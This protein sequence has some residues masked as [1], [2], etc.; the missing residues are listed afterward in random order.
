MRGNPA[1]AELVTCAKK[2]YGTPFLFCHGDYSNRG[3]YALKLADMLTCDQ[4][5]FLLHPYPD[6]DPELTI[7]ETARLYLPHI[8]AAHPV[9]RVSSWW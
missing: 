7:E 5:V 3:F 8:L 1:T 6:P 2:G 4:P 9:R